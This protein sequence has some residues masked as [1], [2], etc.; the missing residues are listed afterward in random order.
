MPVEVII[1]EKYPKRQSQQTRPPDRRTRRFVDK[2]S[3]ALVVI[4]AEHLVRKVPDE[5]MRLAAS[6]VIRGINT[7]CAAGDTIFA[8]SDTSLRGF[9]HEGTVA[10]VAVE[11]VRLCVIG[12]EEIG[13][14]VPVIVEDGDAK[15]LRV[16]VS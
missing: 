8:E 7:H 14:A 10:L 1:E 6:I 5:Q 13:P 11:F 9:L 2:K 16:A 15:G 4:Q 12:H 3:V